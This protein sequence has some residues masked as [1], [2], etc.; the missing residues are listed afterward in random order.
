MNAYTLEIA[1][2]HWRVEPAAGVGLW[3]LKKSGTDSN[4]IPISM[5]R[6]PHSAAVAVAYGLTGNKTWDTRNLPEPA[7]MFALNRWSVEEL[8]AAEPKKK[9]RSAL[10]RAIV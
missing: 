8:D 1:G 7:E 3:L 2:H 9:P 4:W 10:A 6:T 5:Y